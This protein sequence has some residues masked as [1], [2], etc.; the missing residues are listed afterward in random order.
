MVQTTV[1][2]E[3]A[4]ATSPTKVDLSEYES[5]APSDGKAPTGLGSYSGAVIFLLGAELR[6]GKGYARFASEDGSLHEQ[7][8]PIRFVQRYGWQF[9]EAARL[10]KKRAIKGRVKL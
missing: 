7:P 6:E 9:E 2:L 4:E 8:C 3:A 5:V 10:G 1:E